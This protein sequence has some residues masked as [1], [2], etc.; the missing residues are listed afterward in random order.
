M[1]PALLERLFPRLGIRHLDRGFSNL[2]YLAVVHANEEG[3]DEHRLA[4]WTFLA[5]Q[6]GATLRA[7]LLPMSAEQERSLSIR[8]FWDRF[9]MDVVLG[10]FRL[11]FLYY[12]GLFRC[13]GWVGYNPGPDS[14]LFESLLERWVSSLAAKLGVQVPIIDSQS[15]ADDPATMAFNMWKGICTLAGIQVQQVHYVGVAMFHAGI[16]MD[17]KSRSQRGDMT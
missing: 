6:S 1:P 7:L 10:A 5:N 12:I 3:L 15:K 16:S 13:F 9:E 2:Y 11:M 17:F 8:G 14:E 4:L